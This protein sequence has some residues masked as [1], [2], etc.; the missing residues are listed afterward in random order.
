MYKYYNY[1]SQAKTTEIYLEN[2]DRFG[3]TFSRL[4]QV[5]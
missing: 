1:R 3:V 2:T 5:M 4:R